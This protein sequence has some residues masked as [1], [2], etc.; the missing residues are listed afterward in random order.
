M[1]CP[2][3]GLSFTC[4]LFD[5]DIFSRT[6]YRSLE[7]L[8]RAHALLEKALRY[9]DAYRIHV[10]GL[11]RFEC[12]TCGREFS[13][14]PHRESWESKNIRRSL[15]TVSDSLKQRELT[16]LLTLN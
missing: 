6:I 9:P 15:E 7:S 3:K 12:G 2:N 1:I 10:N 13:L 8:D 14:D 11:K 4:L 16:Y 5:C